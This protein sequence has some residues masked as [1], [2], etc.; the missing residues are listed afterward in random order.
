MGEDDK[1]SSLSLLLFEE[2]LISNETW[3]EEVISLLLFIA[4]TVMIPENSRMIA[5]QL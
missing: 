1:Q 4:L 5:P 3:N 2:D